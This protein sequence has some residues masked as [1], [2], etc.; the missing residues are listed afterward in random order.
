MTPV[1][2]EARPTTRQHPP[3]IVHIDTVE[4][5]SVNTTNP[6][7][8]H[9]PS[10]PSFQ[11]MC[12]HGKRTP[13]QQTSYRNPTPRP[14]I[15]HP[16][17]HDILGTGDSPHK[18]KHQQPYSSLNHKAPPAIMTEVGTQDKRQAAQAQTAAAQLSEAP[19]FRQDDKTTATTATAVKLHLENTA[20]SP[21]GSINR[22]SQSV[23]NC[24]GPQLPLAF[25]YL[26]MIWRCLTSLGITAPLAASAASA[27]SALL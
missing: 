26:T 15:R 10:R 27:S 5:D 3:C 17:H 20:P 24:H 4:Y 16:C 13:H 23:Q 14:T 8:T 21:S 12:V 2:T 18:H 11:C 7:T 1:S 25:A 9:H 22:L 6:S 19:S